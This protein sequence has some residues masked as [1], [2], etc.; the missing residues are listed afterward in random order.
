MG[1]FDNLS[2]MLGSS[3]TAKVNSQLFDWIRAISVSLDGNAPALSQPTFVIDPVNG[4]D[5]QTGLTNA[6]ALKTFTEYRNRV[7]NGPLQANQ[8]VTILSNLA[9]TD[10]L[11]LELLD[12]GRFNLTVT[13]QTSV[14]LAA[15]TITTYTPRVIATNTPNQ[16]LP[17]V[18]I[19]WTNFVGNGFFVVPTTGPAVGKQAIVLLDT[20]GGPPTTARLGTMIGLDSSETQPANG[21]TFNILSTPTVVNTKF[22]SWSSGITVQ[23][24]N[25]ITNQVFINSGPNTSLTAQPSPNWQFQYCTFTE[26]PV[27]RGNP[28][29]IGCS[30]MKSSS[31]GKFSLLG[32]G[33]AR[34][35][36]CAFFDPVAGTAW[37]LDEGCLAVFNIGTTFQGCCVSCFA[38]T[39][40]FTNG[41]FFDTTNTAI[42]AR[43]GTNIIANN[44]YGNTG[45]GNPFACTLQR[46]DHVVL[47][48]AGQTLTNGGAQEIAMPLTASTTWAAVRAAGGVKDGATSDASAMVET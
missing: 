38:S 28:S 19:T 11:D 27:I 3:V 34:F 12:T 31:G 1:L 40:T 33:R 43:R 25:F 8:T 45:A 16:L 18:A 39:P 10:T 4:S 2:I 22:G 23:N 47:T 9:A 21:N 20:G 41:A 24:L 5:S 46:E 15:Q 42:L 29:F 37:T 35:N 30:F 14:A 26:P 32:N 44:L 13:G 48:G 36:G 17:T 7:K 6:T